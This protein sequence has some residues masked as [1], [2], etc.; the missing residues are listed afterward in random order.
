MVVMSGVEDA[1]LMEH[2]SSLEDPRRAQGRRHNLLDIVA[3]T[4]CAVV[5][6]AEGWDDVELFAQCKVQW[7]GRFLELPN[8][9]PCSDTFARV[10]ARIDPDRFRDCFRAWVSSVHRLTQGEVIAVDGKTL[11]R[12]HDRRADKEAIHMVSAWATENSLVLGQART[13]AKSNEITAIPELLQLLE[14][15]GCIVSIDAMGCQK[16]IARTILERGADYVLAVKGNQGRLY[17]DLRDLFEGAEES[18]YKGVPHDWATT[19]NKG[20]G[21][22]ERRECRTTSDPSCLEYLSTAGDWPGLRSIGMVRSER[23]EGEHVSV[24]TRYYISSLESDAQ[25]LLGAARSH[26]GIENSVHWVLDVSFREDESRVRTGNAP[27]NLAT[28]RHAA[29]NLLRQ[30][31]HSKRSVKAKRKL[32]AWDNDY[33]LSILSN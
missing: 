17:G 14:V 2:F 25:K 18:G 21:R 11:R 7:F 8:G 19:L 32:A 1:N 16:E 15:S 10:F 6:G 33:L 12:S 23:S 9:I 5:A 3:M 4:I 30:D 26:W 31:R 20:H 22:I 27:E 29:L 13:D 28:M 24:E